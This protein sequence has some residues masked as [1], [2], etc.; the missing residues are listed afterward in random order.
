[1]K[2][3][4]TTSDLHQ[5]PFLHLLIAFAL[6]TLSWLMGCSPK[7]DSKAVYSDEFSKDL[8][9]LKQYFKIPGIAAIVQKGDDIIYEEYMGTANLAA[10][11]PVDSSTVFHLASITKIFS[12]LLTMQL[13]ADGKLSLDSPVNKF[14]DQSSLSDSIQVKH[15]LSHTSQG[16]IGEQFYYSARFGLLTQVL[17]KAGGKPLE[18]L[19]TEE[20]FHPLEMENTFLL[21]DSAQALVLGD[22][23]AL[24]YNYEEQAVEGVMEYGYSTSAGILSNARDLLKL[25]KSLE[26][27]VVL[28]ETHLSQMCSP[29]KDGLPYGFGIFAQQ[30]YGVETLWAYGQYD[31]YS[32]LFI[33]IPSKELTLILLAN[34]N[35]M[36]DPARLI[37]GDIRSSLFALSFLKNFV[38]DQPELKLWQGTASVDF[39]DDNPFLR[40]LV[41]A[42]ALSASFM[43]R[44]DTDNFAVSVSLLQQV[45]EKYPDYLSYADLTLM[46]NLMFLK[47]VAFYRELGAFNYFDPQL[48]GIGEQLLKEDANNPYVHVYL[49]NYYDR[50]GDRDK[51]KYHF[52]Q[53]VEATNFSPN[54]YTREAENWLRQ[55]GN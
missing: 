6:L 19:F 11:I 52:T 17:E 14:L 26:K 9:E 4:S 42:E 12:G 22:R 38:L 39:E 55:D 47:D 53:I 25:S 54:W 3:N 46:H 1:M 33:K 8:T 20:L 50:K 49:G 21:E 40:D 32:S 48:E 7:G 31:S 2:I 15:I 27:D 35:L 51:A 45:F 44:F 41:L 43:A 10:D 16:E 28:D 5:P 34:N 23:L 29:F 37:Y 18:Q 36:S 13:V 24:P 30:L